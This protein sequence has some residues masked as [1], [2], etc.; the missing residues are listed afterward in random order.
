MNSMK[1][2]KGS[3]TVTVIVIV[4]V[5][6]SVTLFYVVVTPNGNDLLMKALGSLQSDQSSAPAP[7]V[8]VVSVAGKKI[9]F[10]DGTR[11]C[12]QDVLMC[13]DGK[14]MKRVPPT[15]TFPRCP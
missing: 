6:I 3:A 15:C 13:S 11:G 14:I 9:T 5:V 8:Q 4:F 7:D 2:E 12:K 10:P 1:K